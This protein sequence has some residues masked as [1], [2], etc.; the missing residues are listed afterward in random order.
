MPDNKFCIIRPIRYPGF[1]GYQGKISCIHPKNQIQDNSTF[2]PASHFL[3]IFPPPLSF[4]Y[5]TTLFSFTC[6][7]KH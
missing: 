5:L 4:F 7:D 2:Y 6:Q 1:A 3:A